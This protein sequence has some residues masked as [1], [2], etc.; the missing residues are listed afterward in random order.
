[1]VLDA[2]AIS[3]ISIVLLLFVSLI[4]TSLLLQQS[5]FAL[6]LYDDFEAPTYTIGDNQISP[7]GKWFSKYNGFG[8]SGTVTI[9]TPTPTGSIIPSFMKN[10]KLH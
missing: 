2:L 8:S 6:V 1:L 7:N 4:T 3:A 10:Q 9:T 5:V